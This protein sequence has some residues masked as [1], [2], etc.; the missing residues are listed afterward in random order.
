MRVELIKK[1][2]ITDEQCRRCIELMEPER[3]AAVERISHQGVRESTVCGEW[4]AKR[5]L[6]EACGIPVEDIRLVREEN[7]KPYA[8]NLP[9]YFSI[10]HSGD[11]VAC[12]VSE[13]PVGLD[14]E[15]KRARDVSAAR[16]ICSG[17]ELDYILVGDGEER[18]LRFLRVW[19]AKEAYVKLTGEG[20]KGMK[21]ADFFELLSRLEV[22]ETEECI[23]SAIEQE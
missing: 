18:L 11:H 20:I 3:R 13:R 2:N 14:I 12:A 6:S 21:K 15:E 10:S 23:L 5:M 19:T 4:L 7:G 17:K 1:E 8:W 16:R 22:Q 9:L